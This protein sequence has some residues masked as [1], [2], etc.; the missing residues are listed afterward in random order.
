MVKKYFR[1]FVLVLVTLTQAATSCYSRPRIVPNNPGN[2]NPIQL[3]SDV[4]REVNLSISESDMDALVSGNSE[5]AFDMFHELIVKEG[6]IFFS[7]YS[8]STCMAMLYAGAEGRTKTEIADVFHYNLSDSSFHPAMNCL[9]YTLQNLTDE[10]ASGE[11]NPDDEIT[12]FRLYVANSFWFQDGLLVKQNYLD[13]ISRNY[14][15]G[16]LFVDFQG[17]SEGCRQ[18]I[19]KWVE[20][21]TFNRIQELI[22]EGE[23]SPETVFTLV[24]AIYFRAE[25]E[26]KFG[27]YQTRRDDVP[28]HLLTG[29]EIIIPLM[30]HS[31]YF[32][33]YESDQFKAVEVNYKDLKASMLIIQPKLENYAQFEQNLGLEEINEIS[34]SLN[35][36]LINLV[37]PK[38]RFVSFF[39][40]NENLKSLGLTKP[41][42][43]SADFSGMTDVNIWIFKVF[44]KA[45][46]L[47]N[48][49]GTEAAAATSI[50]GGLGGGRPRDVYIDS[51]FI[52]VI[53]DNE[54]GSILFMGRVLKP[55]YTQ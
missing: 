38:F 40:L 16:L 25:W 43:N 31:Y 42:G 29:E 7:P 34:R 39:N 32:N 52:F 49:S 27:E 33:F 37:M 1:L 22:P 23:L 17:D 55:E 48:E 5:F 30:E 4:E 44:H 24:N 6:N 2:T 41:F 47:V 13:T 18:S 26:T 14:G 9:D 46:V 54:T 20:D 53:K 19:N 21:R 8:I 10:S 15:S 36:D 3:A 11:F 12:G 28:F 51:P 50:S 45:Y 35:E